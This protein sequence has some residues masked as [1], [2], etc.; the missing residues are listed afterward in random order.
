MFALF[1]SGGER[2]LTKR[3]LQGQIAARFCDTIVLADEDPRGEDPVELL[4]MIA[5]GAEK[6]EKVMGENLFII[7]DRPQAIR[8]TFKMAQ[9]GDIVLLLGKSH[10]NSIIYKDHVMPYDEISEAKKALKEMGYTQEK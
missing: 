8:E 3:P 5:E 2:D 6:E 9:K 4:K 7:H 10:E 1:G